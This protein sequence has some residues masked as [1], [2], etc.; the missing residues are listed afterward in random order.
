[1]FGTLGPME[2]LLIAFI[3]LMIF[4]AKR[5]PEAGAGLGKAIRSF[6]DSLMSPEHSKELDES[7]P[8]EPS[9]SEKRDE[10]KS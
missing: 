10:P 7:S 4:G 5:L 6:K 2:L 1:M 3:V 9:A 8:V